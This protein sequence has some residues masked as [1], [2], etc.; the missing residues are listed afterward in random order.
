MIDGYNGYTN[1]ET[2]CVQLHLDNEQPSQEYWAQ[3][4]RECL[5]SD[6][7]DAQFNLAGIMKETV[8]SECPDLPGFY[9]DLVR[10]ALSDVNW[11]EIAGHYIDAAKEEV[12]DANG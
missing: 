10:A 2:W 1:Y 3:L 12:S 4:A 6:A 8:E 9:G 7:Y 11:N 5:E